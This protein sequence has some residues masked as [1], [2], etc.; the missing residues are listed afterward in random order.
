[1]RSANYDLSL[2]GPEN[3]LIVVDLECNICIYS[4]FASQKAEH[5]STFKLAS[6]I[7]NGTLTGND[8]KNDRSGWIE[9]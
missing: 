5:V 1:M 7:S 3:Y 6:F 2:S 4:V 8:D 9:G